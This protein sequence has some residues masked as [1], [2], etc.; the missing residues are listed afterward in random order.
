MKDCLV[1]AAYA[2]IAVALAAYAIY[3]LLF[4][5]KDKPMSNATA[6]THNGS[7]IKAELDKARA[8]PIGTSVAAHGLG[9]VA[10]Y[11][12]QAAEYD[13]LALNE[14]VLSWDGRV[15]L[16]RAAYALRVMAGRIEGTGI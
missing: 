2:L 1:V 8:R 12:A 3:W 10:E 13:D 16:A 11:R 9:S 4:P 7:L 14:P 5:P 15:R 6:R